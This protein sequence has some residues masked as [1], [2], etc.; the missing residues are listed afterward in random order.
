MISANR[1]G[2]IA[3]S[4]QSRK[5]AEHVAHLT[6][7]DLKGV[8]HL[9]YHLLKKAGYAHIDPESEFVDGFVVGFKNACST[10][11]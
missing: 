1:R 4:E 3:G 7:A 10:S 6:E 5:Q 11:N 9:T 8:A 2:V